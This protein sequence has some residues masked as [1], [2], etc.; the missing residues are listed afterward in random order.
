MALTQMAS[1]HRWKI[2]GKICVCCAVWG[3]TNG[4]ENNADVATRFL[5]S[6]PFGG[7]PNS[8]GKKF[9]LVRRF[10][11]FFFVFRHFPSIFVLPFT[12]EEGPLGVGQ[13]FAQS[14]AKEE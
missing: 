4:G 12:K 9:A 13:F 5:L 14:F 8:V 6:P 7:H 11:F 1:S 10:I 2:G 3:T